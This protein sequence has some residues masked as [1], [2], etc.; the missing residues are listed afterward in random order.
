M[1][2]SKSRFT[3]LLFFAAALLIVSGCAR[4]SSQETF[5]SVEQVMD[6]TI[7]KLYATLSEEELQA[8]DQQQALSLFNEEDLKVLATRHSS[9]DV[10]VPVTVSVIRSENQKTL[11]F[12]L[13]PAGFKKTGLKMHNSSSGYE[14]WQ[15]DFDKGTVGL[16]I[17]GFENYSYH[18]LIS[19]A[20]QNKN[21]ELI[22]S[23]FIPENQYVGILN[24]GAFTYHDWTELVLKDVPEEMKGQ[25]LLTSV[26]G[27]GKESH[28][29]G[30]FRKTD[31]P[32]SSQPD[33]VLLTWSDDPASSIDIQWRTGTS[34]ETGQVMFRKTGNDDIKT[35]T[36]EKYEM[37]DRELMNDRY[38]NR[39]TA[40]LKNL[41]PGT[42]YEYLIAPETDWSK[43]V[44]FS[45]PRQDNSFSFVW[46][47][48]NHHKPEFGELH[49]K[50]ENKHPETAFYISS[51]DIVDYGLYR[52]EWDNV[53]EFSKNVMNKKPFMAVPGNHDNRLGLGSKMFR[54]LFSYPMNGPDGVP[55]EQTYSFTYENALFLMLDPTNDVEEQTEWIEKQLAASTATWKF[56][57]FHFPPYNWKEPYPDIQKE[58]VPLFDKY[59]V[60]MV[61][62][63]HMH[64][65]MRSKPLN[66]GKTV[67]SFADG[68]IYVI[69]LAIPGRQNEIPDEPYAEVRELKCS[70]Y[71]YFKIEGNKLKYKSENI[72]GEI[73]DSFE[74]VK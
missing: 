26:R 55:K 30:A 16:G 43:A 1:H 61:L 34:V 4:Q 37:E 6:E 44:A 46:F 28:L 72:H 8:I 66:D 25:K 31:F 52:N 67:K 18:Y 56:A 63:G 68:T 41:A 64:Y 36:A 14:V 32:S 20:P 40:K 11:P 49:E 51:G 33:Q 50:A 35:V 13:E 45:T 42:G 65:Y 38:I 70:L 53:F 23:N 47:G 21:D 74:I 3:K 59:H 9:F 48:D 24:D 54:D 5:K 29:I 57:V 27:R 58:W 7:S 22:L 39:F 17:N 15:K 69:S 60:D 71:Q 73:V 19:V 10:N 62:T 12:W 2:I